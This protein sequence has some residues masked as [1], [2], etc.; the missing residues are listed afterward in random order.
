MRQT[1]VPAIKRPKLPKR[2]DKEE[3]IENLE[4]KVVVKRSQ[5]KRKGNRRDKAKS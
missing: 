1:P 2:K 5:Q 3:E 4:I